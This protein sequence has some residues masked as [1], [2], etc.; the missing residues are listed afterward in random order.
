MSDLTTH[1]LLPWMAA[2]QAQ[3]HVTFNEALRLLDGLVQ[4]AV[5]D[6]H[7]T[8]PPAAP[9]APAAPADGD[10]H[11]VAPG[12]SGPW[13]G[14]DGSVA[15]FSD[16][17]WLRLP[18]REGWTAWDAAA[19]ELLVRAA[20][21]WTP[22]AEAL[23][24]VRRGPDVAVARAPHGSGLR[25]V[26]R[27]E[28]LA[29]LAGPSVETSLVFP[30]RALVL[31][32]S[33]RVVEAISGATGFDLGVAGEPARFGAD[34][35]TAAGATHAGAIAPPIVSAD[36]PVRL[37]ALGGDFAGGAVRIALHHLALDPPA[38]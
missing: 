29:G 10:R 33:A 14:W 4:L 19:G 25:M 17:A 16:G 36:V 37:T 20:A 28:L 12:A 24:L 5:R 35:G 1:L 38:A 32:V 2:A 13:A 31:G 18:A 8:A 27:E 11:L 21:G 22:L 3:K 9:A 34:L 30:E 23:D 26:V 6:A 15:V 7:R